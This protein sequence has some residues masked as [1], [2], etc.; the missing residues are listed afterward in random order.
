MCKAG[1]TRQIPPEPPDYQNG[2][3]P[4]CPVAMN[5]EPGTPSGGTTM[6]WWV[7]MV[8]GAAATAF[9][10][11]ALAVAR[12]GGVSQL[13]LGLTA[14]GKAAHDPA[15]GEKLNTLLAG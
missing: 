1:E 10:I 3:R 4:A 2:E 9:L 5:L 6:D 8:I 11:L 14:A 7:G 13:K 12:A 15:F